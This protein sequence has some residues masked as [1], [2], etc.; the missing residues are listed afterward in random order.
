MTLGS[1]KPSSAHEGVVLLSEWSASETF[2]ATRPIEA[3][4]L[5]PNMWSVYDIFDLRKSLL[6]EPKSQLAED[7][8]SLQLGG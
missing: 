2:I 8:D 1:A 3:A 5:E 7:A 4:Y 6:G